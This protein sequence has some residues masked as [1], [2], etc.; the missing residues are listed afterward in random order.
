M[1]IAVAGASGFVGRVLI[2]ELKKH[3]QVV[4]LSRSKKQSED[5]IEW[6]SCDLFSMLDAE[7]AMHDVDVAVYLVHSMRPSAHLTQGTFDDFD[8]IVADNFV[9][10]AQKCGVKQIVYLGGM[11]PE[12]GEK[13]SAHLRSRWEVE[14]VFKKSPIASTVLRAAIILGAEGSSFHIMTRLVQRLPAML[15]PAWT[16]TESQPVAL[17]DVLAAILYCVGNEKTF[18]KVYDL[19]GSDKVSYA[20][21]MSKIA[22]KMG[23]KRMLIPVPFLSPK[24]SALWLCF[25]TGAPKELVRPLIHGLKIPLLA[26]PQR[27]LH[28]PGHRYLTVDE[29]LD[30]AL[31]EF[32]HK[33]NPIAFNPSPAGKHVVR[34]VQRLALAGRISAEEVARAY[35]N[36]LPKSQPGFLR[37]DVTGR[38]IYFCWRF[39]LTRLLVLEH[40][41][42]R[43]GSDRQ[44]FYVRGGLLARKTVRGRLEFREILG[45]EAV[46]AAIH[47]FQPRLP[48]YLYL[49]TQAFFHLWVMKR[50]GK[51]LI[52]D[53]DVN[54][55]APGSSASSGT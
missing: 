34:S 28:I 20:E 2:E 53:K 11:R 54:Y 22:H 37:V 44:L 10:A 31:K 12:D 26:R 49:W 23:L 46:I 8:L 47:D 21:M 4:G 16:H 45:G 52:N 15:C 9:R 40:S 14:Q 36:F 42:E 35:M 13:M 19:C 25:I 43:S 5:N 55:T 39:P 27:L 3:H 6:R 51:H 1:K 29:A 50:F 38:W 41:P 32:N 30:V 48:W 24:I 17:Q 7:K 33:D 18:N